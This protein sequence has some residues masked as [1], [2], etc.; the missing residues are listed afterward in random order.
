MFSIA[1]QHSGIRPAGNALFR[2]NGGNRLAFRFQT[3]GLIGPGAGGHHAFVFKIAHL[4]GGIVPVAVDQ[5]VLFA[6]D[7]Q[8][9]LILRFGKLIGIINTQLRL[10]GFNE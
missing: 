1:V 7:F 9:R 2:K 6:Q 3:V 10:S 5:R 8:H 4:H